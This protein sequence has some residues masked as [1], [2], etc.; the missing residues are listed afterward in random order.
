MASN[1]VTLTADVARLPF[2]SDELDG[3]VSTR[4]FHHGL[5]EVLPEIARTLRP[6]GPW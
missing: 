3:A 2:G 5:D 4:T 6:G 1:V